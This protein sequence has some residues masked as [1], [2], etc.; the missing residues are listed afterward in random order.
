M[1]IGGRIAKTCEIY[2]KRLCRNIIKGLKE[3]LKH[4]GIMTEHGVGQIN[5]VSDDPQEW[6]NGWEERV[7]PHGPDNER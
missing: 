4:R 2:P 5:Q 3:Q 7:S 6:N 1:H